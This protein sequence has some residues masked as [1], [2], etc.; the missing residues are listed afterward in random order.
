M[1]LQPDQDNVE[2]REEVQTMLDPRVVAMGLLETSGE[3][4]AP[5]LAL[6]FR[7]VDYQ[8]PRRDCEAENIA[9]VLKLKLLNYQLSYDNTVGGH[10]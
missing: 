1:A 9:K 6:V 3:M 8:N 7:L 4:V 2:P 10:D 5:T